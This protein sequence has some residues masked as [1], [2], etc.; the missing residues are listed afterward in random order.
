MKKKSMI[1]I[2]IIFLVLIIF[3]TPKHNYAGTLENAMKGS[4]QI[5][6]TKDTEKGIVV[7]Y[8][9]VINPNSVNTA[10]IKRN[11]FGYYWVHGTG[12]DSFDSKCAMTYGY[13]NIGESCE[14]DSP[15]AF[16]MVHDIITND[17]IEAVEVQLSDGSNIKADIIQTKLGKIWYTFLTKQTSYTPK[18]TGTGKDGKVIFTN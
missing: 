1:N 11:L 2:L 15:K 6:Y 13:S 17:N 5:L 10:L 7:F 4:R 3:A 18:I 8:E 12:T 9:P 14:A 16:P